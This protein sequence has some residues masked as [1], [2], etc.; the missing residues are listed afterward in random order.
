VTSVVESALNRNGADNAEEPSAL[1]KAIAAIKNRTPEEKAAAS[2]RAVRT[3]KP[4]RELPPGKTLEDMVA[5]KW[6]GDE[7]DDQIREALEKLS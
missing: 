7:T 5:G 4:R 1:D 6:P 3:Y 2:E